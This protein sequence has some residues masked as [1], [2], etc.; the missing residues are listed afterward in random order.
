[1]FR[2]LGVQGVQGAGCLRCWVFSVLGV[3]GAGCSGCLDMHASICL[4][5]H[6]GLP[7]NETTIAEC[8]KGVGYS[9][10]MVGKWYLV[11]I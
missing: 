3:Q 5:M 6:A 4:T 10:G 7:F 9:T 2:V 8:L 11:S 1:M